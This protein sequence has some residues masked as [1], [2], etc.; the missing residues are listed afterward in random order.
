MIDSLSS[1]CVNDQT[2]GVEPSAADA[3]SH[4]AF[5]ANTPIIVQSEPAAAARGSVADKNQFIGAAV[6][7]VPRE[8]GRLRRA[9]R[10]LRALGRIIR[11]AGR[12]IAR[13]AWHFLH[14]ILMILSSALPFFFDFDEKCGAG[15]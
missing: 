2:P 12:K 14:S 9:P 8:C 15:L 7:P 1:C 5:P 10:R 3:G 4:R 11:S 13:T 6:C